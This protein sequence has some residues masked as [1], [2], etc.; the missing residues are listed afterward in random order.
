MGNLP[1]EQENKDLV[2]SCLAVCGRCHWDEESPAE[3]HGFAM[4]ESRGTE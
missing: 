1:L 4:A 3:T 2:N